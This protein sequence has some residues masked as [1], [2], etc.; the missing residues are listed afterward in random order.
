MFRV[1]LR[2]KPQ[3]TRTIIEEDSVAKS[4]N[5]SMSGLC[6]VHWPKHCAVDSTRHLLLYT[7]LEKLIG[8][9]SVSPVLSSAQHFR[10]LQL[11]SGYIVTKS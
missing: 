11:C 2:G 9:L 7:R 4:C 8:Q 6:R 1:G 5:G 3:G 10:P